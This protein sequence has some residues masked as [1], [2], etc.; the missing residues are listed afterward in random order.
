MLACLQYDTA[1]LSPVKELPY[2]TCPWWYVIRIIL[3]YYVDCK[4]LRDALQLVIVM[5]PS[6]IGMM[7][8]RWA[9]ALLS[10]G[11]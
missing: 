10:S 2:K 4:R 3:P 5:L 11:I 7:V 6:T 1:T 8:N 9:Q